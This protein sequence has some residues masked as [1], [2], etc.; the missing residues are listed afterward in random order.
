MEN[1]GI[2]IKKKLRF[3]VFKRDAFTCQYCGGTTPAVVLEL[4]HIHPVSKGGDNSIDNLLTACFDCNRGKA[5]GLLTS[6]PKSLTDKA[7]EIAERMEQV[8]AYEKL[9]KAQHKAIEKSIDLV[10]DEFNKKHDGFIFSDKFRQ[11]V[12]YFLERLT[13]FQ[14]IEAME[15]ACV[16]IPE[17][18]DAIRYFSGI[19]WN[20]IKGR[21][22]GRNA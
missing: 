15:I 13:Q 20:K 1:V 21:T 9:L 3:D 12:R 16:R 11:S 17:R 2:P 6:I 14:V 4:D 22:D 5:G 8:K 19:C 10:Q 7:I 18:N